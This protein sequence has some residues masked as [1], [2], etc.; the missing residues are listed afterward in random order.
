MFYSNHTLTRDFGDHHWA[1]VKEICNLKN[2]DDAFILHAVD[3]IRQAYGE[4]EVR[5]IAEG[6]SLTVPEPA[7]GIGESFD[8]SA[9]M[10]AFRK[11]LP[12]PE[13]EGNK[14]SQLTNYRS[15][16]AELIAR[17]ALARV[18]GFELPPA[19]HATKGN[20]AQP[21]LGLDG[22]T[23]IR[24]NPEG[25]SLALIQVKATDDNRR[26]PGE[27]AK[28]VS[29][30]GKAVTDKAKLSSY[31]MACTVR[32]RGTEYAAMILGMVQELEK[33]GQIKNLILSPVIIRGEVE[34]DLEDLRSLR[35]ATVSY[36]HAKARGMTLS[37]GAELT[38]LGRTA[39]AKARADD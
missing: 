3:V 37:L 13:A 27:A 29:E 28:L 16:T 38:A 17:A 8:L 1:V 5:R 11:A 33:N 9:V 6:A 18:Y 31:L 32:C 2:A 23:V 4:E 25:L 39:M 21:I 19:L 22:W 30:C 36:L 10:S 12:D 24:T 7:E 34:A 35:D 15:E 26:P 14:P 20:R